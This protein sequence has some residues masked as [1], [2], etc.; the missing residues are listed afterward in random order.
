MSVFDEWDWDKVEQTFHSL[1]QH[2]R[3][4]PVVA[5]M[6]GLT[7][8]LRDEPRLAAMVPVVSHFTLTLRAPGCT[9]VVAV[10]CDESEGGAYKVA[11]VDPPLEFR[12]TKQFSDDDVVATVIEYVDRLQTI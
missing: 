3:T 1:E 2:V 9:S 12:Q 7:A 6:L 8:R 5:R 11:F 4:R 10:W